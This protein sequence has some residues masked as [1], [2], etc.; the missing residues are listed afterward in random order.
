[1]C[2]ENLKSDLMPVGLRFFTSGMQKFTVPL[3]KARA[4]GTQAQM[5]PLAG[6]WR[7]HH[8]PEFMCSIAIWMSRPVGGAFS[9]RLMSEIALAAVR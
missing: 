1:M 3:N 2:T 7:K 5:A 8:S 9:L 4:A 6:G